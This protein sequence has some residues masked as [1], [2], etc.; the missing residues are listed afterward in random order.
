[1]AAPCYYCSLYRGTGSCGLH[2]LRICGETPRHL[3]Q[4]CGL[5]T[6]CDLPDSDP[7]D[8]WPFHYDPANIISCDR[9]LK[10][11]PKRC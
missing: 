11:E 10:G 8:H 4:R 7:L 1:M 5:E 2:L 3:A 6:L 9:H